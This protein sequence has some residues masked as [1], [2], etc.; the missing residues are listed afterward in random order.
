[1]LTPIILIR[2]PVEQKKFDPDAIDTQVYCINTSD[3]ELHIKLNE[4]SFLT[5]DEENGDAVSFS[6]A[7]KEFILAPEQAHLISEICGWE[8]DGHVGVEL[9]VRSADNPEAK[10]YSYDFKSGS[11]D[12]YFE[13]QKVNARIIPAHARKNK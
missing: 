6:G 1:M 3:H 11:G 12:Y 13:E 5:L 8:W 9:S 10:T 7:K 2:V 4:E